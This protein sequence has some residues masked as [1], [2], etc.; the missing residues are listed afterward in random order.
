MEKEV[1]MAKKDNNIIWILV[2]FILCGLAITGYVVA[3]RKVKEAKGKTNISTVTSLQEAEIKTK[4]A[5]HTR[6]VSVRKRSARIHKR[7]ISAPAPKHAVYYPA[8]PRYSKYT[9]DLAE[10]KMYAQQVAGYTPEQTVKGGLIGGA[11][12]AAAGAAIGAVLG[13]AGKGAAIGAAAGGIGAGTYSAINAERKY[14]K[15]Y[16]RCMRQRGYR[17]LN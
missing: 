15:A 11:V 3:H 10:C 5:R 4:P 9:R 14:K 17:V 2:F 12:G 1:E 7:A 6:E 16:A 8:H 13:H